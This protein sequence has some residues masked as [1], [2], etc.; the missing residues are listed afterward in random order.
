VKD[1]DSIFIGC[2]ALAAFT[3]SSW[4]QAVCERH[5]L[6]AHYLRPLGGAVRL[7]NEKLTTTVN[8]LGDPYP[9]NRYR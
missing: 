3:L 1:V 5:V 8:R 4:L 2:Y 7:N 6:A 9:L